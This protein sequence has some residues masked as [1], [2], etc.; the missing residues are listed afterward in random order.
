MGV[1]VRT[2]AAAVLVAG[3]LGMPAAGEATQPRA[4]GWLVTRSASGTGVLTGTM[5][6]T[7]RGPGASVVMFALT[8]VGAAR[9]HDPAVGTT[10]ADWGTDGW[11]TAYAPGVTAPPC[12]GPACGD[13]VKTPLS[14]AFSSNG[15]RVSSTMLIAAW[16][17]DSTVAVTSPG[18]RVRPWRP[19]MRVVRADQGGGAGARA[20][21]TTAGTFAKAEAAGGRHGSIAFASLPC[22]I[23][24]DGAGEFTGGT[25]EYALYCGGRRSWRS[26]SPGPTRWRLAGDARGVDGIVNVLVVVDYP[27]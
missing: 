3:V 12:Q 7:A 10:R 4:T 15:H 9:R 16:D 22:G 6:A 5:S 24:G 17:A 1:V 26:G 21:H 18:W 19:A 2:V 20:L 14:I 27:K 13:P 25:R 23:A 11:A 8:G